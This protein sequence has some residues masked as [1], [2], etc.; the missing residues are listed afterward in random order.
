MDRDKIKIND[1]NIPV[2]PLIPV[3]FI[4]YFCIIEM[5]EAI[6]NYVPQ[7]AV[8]KLR[9]Q[10][11]FVW[12]AVAFLTT[13]WIFLIVIAPI[14]QANNLPSVAN[15]IYG[16]C[17]F[18]CHQIPARSFFIEN[19]PFAV[20]SRCFGIYFGLFAGF[21]LYPV[22]RSLEKNEPFSRFWLFLA[23]IPM[24]IDWSLGFFE[25][26][27]NTHLSRFLTGLILGAA[28]AVFI[29]PALVEIFRLLFSRRKVKRLPV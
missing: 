16:F 22:I 10:A 17:S 21:I 1:L 19:Q 15:P 12:S 26:W 13:L 2:R 3:N 29:V 24:G 5:P 11:L 6:E 25:I 18:V 14:A 4:L 23:M 8:E 27:E 20:C 28:C 9:R 7:I